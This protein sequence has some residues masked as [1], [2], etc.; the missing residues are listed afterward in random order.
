MQF[1]LQ[2]WDAASHNKLDLPYGPSYESKLAPLQLG[3]FSLWA[4]TCQSHTHTHTRN[5]TSLHLNCSSTFFLSFNFFVSQVTLLMI[6]CVWVRQNSLSTEQSR[7]YKSN[8]SRSGLFFFVDKPS[9][10]LCLCLQRVSTV[11][12]PS[13]SQWTCQRWGAARSLYGTPLCSGCIV[14]V[15]Y[16][17]PRVVY[18]L[19]LLVR[20]WRIQAQ[21]PK[22]Q[23]E[24]VLPH[25]WGRHLQ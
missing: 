5:D 2:V 20:A 16:S 8:A 24:V 13:L 21:W 10:S 19:V 23:I 11:D 12:H 15:V 25:Q 3:P 22:L 17:L 14:G 6:L 18:V 9:A 7:F 4:Y 1:E